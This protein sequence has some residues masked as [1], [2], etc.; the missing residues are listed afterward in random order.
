MINVIRDTAPARRTSVSSHLSKPYSVRESAA[1]RVP[2]TVK[3][4]PGARPP[5]EG[6]KSLSPIAKNSPLTA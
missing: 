4:F 2:G 5:D 1:S 6:Y 3:A